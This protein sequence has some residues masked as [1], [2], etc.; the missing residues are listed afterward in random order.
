MKASA[1]PALLCVLAA[2]A[3]APLRAEDGSRW[4]LRGYGLWLSPAGDEVRVVR[5]GSGGEE[6]TTHAISEDGA[7]FGLGLEYLWRPRIGVELGAFVAG[8]DSDFRLEAGGVP[9]TDREEMGITAYTLGVNWH[10]RPGRRLEASLGALVALSFYD[11]VIFLTE[12]GRREK[13]FVDDD[14]GFGAQAA[15]EVPFGRGRAWSLGA[16]LRY[17]VTI[18]ES[19][20]PGQD[21]E[22]SPLILS[23]GVGYRFGGR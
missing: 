12:A 7:G 9:L 14:Y 4:V 19:E 1:L 3:G 2:A 16:G 18:L 8:V 20:V 23:V 21:L 22:L 10:L 11:D 15:I 6:T 13:V 5:P 17:L